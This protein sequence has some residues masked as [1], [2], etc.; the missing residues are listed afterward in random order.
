MVNINLA[1]S[2]KSNRSAWEKASRYLG[3][4]KLLIESSLKKVNI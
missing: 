2:Q 4:E 1:G 3:E